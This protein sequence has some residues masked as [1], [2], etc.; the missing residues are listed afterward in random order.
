MN[1]IIIALLTVKAIAVAMAIAI[2]L[3]SNT[4]SK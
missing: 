2:H 1:T 3:D 4:S